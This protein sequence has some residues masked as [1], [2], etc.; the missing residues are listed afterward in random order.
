MG[1]NGRAAGVR[2]RAGVYSISFAVC[3]LCIVCYSTLICKPYM[4]RFHTQ[5]YIVCVVLLVALCLYTP[6]TNTAEYI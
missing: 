4:T 3:T 2:G 1:I 6:T 5:W